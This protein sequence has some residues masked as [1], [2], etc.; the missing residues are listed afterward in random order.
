[1]FW[2]LITDKILSLI[3]SDE[4]Q[5]QKLQQIGMDAAGE[6]KLMA[7]RDQMMK[8]AKTIDR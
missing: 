7:L 5:L 3:V 2:Y 6:A 8:L 1:M 4:L